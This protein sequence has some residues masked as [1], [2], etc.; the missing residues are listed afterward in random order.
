MH[1]RTH[2]S[3]HKFTNTRTHTHARAHTHTH[4]HTHTA[5]TEACSSTPSTL[6]M[7]LG[8]HARTNTLRERK[9]KK[10]KQTSTHGFEFLGVSRLRFNVRLQGPGFRVWGLGFRVLRLGWR[11]YLV[12]CH[13]GA[14]VGTGHCVAVPMCQVFLSPTPRQ[15]SA[16]HVWALFRTVEMQN[17][18]DEMHVFFC[19]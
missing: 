5:R 17:E 1:L 12:G 8:I 6:Q 3:T 15:K 7:H 19:Q 10:G 18:E 2:I 16:F 4:T 13:I 9:T 14:W 11:V